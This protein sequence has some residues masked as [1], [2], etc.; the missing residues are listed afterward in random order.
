LRSIFS[1]YL[2]AKHAIT[3]IVDGLLIRLD[4]VSEGFMIALCSLFDPFAF[5]ILSM[6]G[7]GHV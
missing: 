3:K 5:F 6:S 4:D 7:G 1:F 2:V